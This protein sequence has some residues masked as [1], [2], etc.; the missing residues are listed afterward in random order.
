MLKYI[1]L[2]ETKKLSYLKLQFYTD[3][4]VFSILRIEHRRF[5]PGSNNRKTNQGKGRCRLKSFGGLNIT[6][7]TQQK[8]G[9]S[10]QR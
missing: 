9:Q 5:C 10:V 3:Q 1:G 7:V 4:T 2:D 8:D 6:G